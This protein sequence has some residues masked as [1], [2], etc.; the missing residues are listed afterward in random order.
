MDPRTAHISVDDRAFLF[1]DGV[2]EVIRSYD[3]KL[4]SLAEH[5]RRLERSMAAV[6]LALPGG[7]DPARLVSDLYRQ[8]GLPDAK[9]YLQVT[10]GS[11]PRNHLFSLDLEPNV[12][13]NVSPLP[14]RG[15]DEAPLSVITTSDQRWQMCHVKTTSLIA[16]VLARHQA[17][18][19]GVDDAVFIREGIVTEATSSNVFLV[20]DGCLYTHPA[21]NHILAGITRHHI[22]ALAAD[23][24]IPVREEKCAQALLAAANEVFLSG[25]LHEVKPVSRIDGQP[26]NDGQPGPVTV[27]LQAAFRELTR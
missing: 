24:G 12:Y 1:G 19:A 13:I 8:S 27:L 6:D 4:F 3:G 15:G 18:L 20:V 22:L 26:V 25:T 7:L 5:L 9:V 10:R 11:E 16:N 23:R 14:S 21:D 2:Y 17:R